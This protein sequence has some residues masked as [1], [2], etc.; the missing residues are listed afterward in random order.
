MKKYLTA[1][2]LAASFVFMPAQ[3]HSA[4]VLWAHDAAGQLG[5]VD[6]ADSTVKI[7]G[8][9]GVVMTDIAYDPDGNLWGI[10]TTDLYRINPATAG[11]TLVGAHNIPQGNALVFGTDGLLYAAG[12]TSTKLFTLNPATGSGTSIGSTGFFSA[13][14]LAFYHGSL[15][16]SSTH[17]ELIRIDLNN[18]AVGTKIGEF[19]FYNVYGLATADNDTL[20]GISATKIFSVDITTG[21]G[22]LIQDYKGKALGSSYGSS[23]ITEATRQPAVPVPPTILLLGSTLPLLLIFRKRLSRSL[24]N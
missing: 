4:P 22:T 14:D 21:Q 20:Y 6:L 15:Y 7:T 10:S 24:S 3:A 18:N 23:F 12:G 9:M 1:I 17:S 11:T 13:G 5:T 2:I 8:N 16:L 19:G